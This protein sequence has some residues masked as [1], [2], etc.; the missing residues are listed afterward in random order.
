MELGLG[1][2]LER[3]RRRVSGLVLTVEV[4]VPVGV[5]LGG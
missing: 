2:G 4:P 1:R 5:R 3:A